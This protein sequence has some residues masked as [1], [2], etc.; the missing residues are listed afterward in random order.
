[1]RRYCVIAAALMLAALG[2]STAP[3]STATQ[4]SQP[5][6]PIITKPLP[7]PPAGE[8]K[9]AGNPVPNPFTKQEGNHFDRTA[10][11]TD[12]PGNSH[13]EIRDILIPPKAKSTVAALP[14]SAVMDL[15]NGKVTLA[16]GD[17]REELS[18][19]PMRALPG[20]Q[21]LEFENTDSQPASI[22]LFIIRA[23]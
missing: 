6:P 16:M 2:C 5:K 20:G 13:I 4:K 8:L 17:K 3:D 15:S 23:R 7:P 18:G 14:G 1:M 21:A 12:G 10:F 19:G 9:Y 11:E 22:R